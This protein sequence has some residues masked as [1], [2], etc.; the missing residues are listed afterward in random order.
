LCYK[1]CLQFSLRNLEDVTV[2]STTDLRTGL[3]TCSTQKKEIKW[4]LILKVRVF[5]T[6]CWQFTESLENFLIKFIKN[7]EL[8]ITNSRHNYVSNCDLTT[9]R[10][11]MFKI[12]CKFA[13]SHTKF[14]TTRTTTTQS[15]KILSRNSKIIQT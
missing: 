4:K 8:S 15:P 12:T 13:K 2:F 11:L 9:R 14:S 5:Q 1:H 10:I 3:P 7:F 6:N